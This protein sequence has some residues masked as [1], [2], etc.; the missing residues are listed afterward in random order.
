MVA[1]YTLSIE[2]QSS[3][4]TAMIRAKKHK[5][6]IDRSNQGRKIIIANHIDQA[7]HP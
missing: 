5:I 7:I 3:E 6:I 2:L 4:H 1:S